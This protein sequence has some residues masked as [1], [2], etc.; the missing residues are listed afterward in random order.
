MA[1]RK[2]QYKDMKKYKATRKRQ[3]RRW[4][5]RTG[6]GKYPPRPWTPAEEA[7]VMEKSMPDRELS[8]QIKRSVL[9]IQKRRHIL[10]NRV[11]H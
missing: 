5:K 2:S 11:L 3:L 8:K 6:S 9:A 4:R 10:N 7:A 1:L